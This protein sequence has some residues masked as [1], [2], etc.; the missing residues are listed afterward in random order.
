M[1]RQGAF[2]AWT[3]GLTRH[4]A[5]SG[6]QVA[7]RAALAGRRAAAQRVPA[8]AR[9]LPA[10]R[11]GHADRR[12]HDDRRRRGLHL[13]PAAL[14]ATPSRTAAPATFRCDGRTRCQQ[15]GSCAEARYFLAHCPG[16]KIDGDGDG[17]PCEDHLCA[18][19]R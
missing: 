5:A 10:V 9:R 3:S 6:R 18:A 15:L 8:A 1:G 11:R 2:S 4:L 7:T 16:V 14:P 17:I 19:E 13:G 12:R